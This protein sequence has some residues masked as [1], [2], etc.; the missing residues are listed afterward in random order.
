MQNI[1]FA[2]YPDMLASS[3]TLPIEMLKAGESFAKVRD[4]QAERLCISTTAATRDPVTTRSGL[5]MVADHTFEDPIAADIVFLP[6]LWRNPR[7]VLKSIPAI[8]PWLKWQYENGA[9]ISAVGTGVCFLAEADLLDE[10][11]ATTHWHYFDQFQADYPNVLLK[12]QYFITQSGNL[13]CTASV[14]ALADLTVHFIQRI[15][16]SEVA[17]LVERHFSHEIRRSYE[18]SSYFD[19]QINQHP[20]EDI[21][22]A[23]MWLHDNYSKDIRFSEVASRFEMSVRSFNRRFKAATNKSPLQYLQE[24]RIQTAKDLLKT[25]NLTISEIAYKVGYSD[26]GHFT[27]LFKKL[28][29]T[30]PSDYRTTV[31]AKLFKADP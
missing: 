11:A 8:Y 16:N 9:I 7:R 25:S 4:R 2:L 13:F 27:G 26:M 14:N 30:T 15:Y 29:A 28:L 22:Q 12:R 3:A 6:A 19:G 31:R 21:V 18:T 17:N 24:I 10:K 20:D 5:K 23:Q 1:T